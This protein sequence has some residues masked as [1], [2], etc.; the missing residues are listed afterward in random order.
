MNEKQDLDNLLSKRKFKDIKDKEIFKQDYEEH[1]LIVDN[2]LTENNIVHR[3]EEIVD[4]RKNQG[5]S[6]IFSE[7]RIYD[8]CDESTLRFTYEFIFSIKEKKFFFWDEYHATVRCRMSE[9]TLLRSKGDGDKS[10]VEYWSF[11]G[12]H[13]SMTTNATEQE[14]FKELKEIIIQL[15]TRRVWKS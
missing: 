4:W 14:M 7:H 2:Y 15:V 9:P 11:A 5:I 1:K 13:T 10:L 12:R 8:E 3:L 6:E